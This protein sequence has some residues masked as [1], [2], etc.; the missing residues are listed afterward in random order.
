MFGRGDDA[1]RFN[2][3]ITEVG[4]CLAPIDEVPVVL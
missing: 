2:H 4:N 1:F 3:T